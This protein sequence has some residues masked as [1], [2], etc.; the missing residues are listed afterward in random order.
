MSATAELEQLQKKKIELENEWASLEQ[1]EKSLGE[2]IK[3]L[4]E[5]MAV[6]DLQ[7]KVKAKHAFVEQLE[8]TKK[9]LEQKLSS[10][11]EKREPHPMPKAPAPQTAEKAQEP[12]KQP[13]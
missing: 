3:I 8:S 2:N 5:K 10:P 6:H 1:K 11:Q 9:D 13:V 7:E 12:Q 4:K